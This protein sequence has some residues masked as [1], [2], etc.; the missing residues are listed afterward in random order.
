MNVT[1]RETDRQHLC[2]VSLRCA[3]KKRPEL[4]KMLNSNLQQFLT[5]DLLILIHRNVDSSVLRC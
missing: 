2:C 4:N 5:A 1:N 3:A